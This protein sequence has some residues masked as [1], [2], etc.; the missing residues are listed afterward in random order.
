ML[1]ALS[2]G[3]AD[4]ADALFL[5]AFIIFV[6]IFVIKATVAAADTTMVGRLDLAAAGL[7]CL[8]LAWFVL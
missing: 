7:A 3:H 1:A 8:S 6:V 5:A 4:L 2:S